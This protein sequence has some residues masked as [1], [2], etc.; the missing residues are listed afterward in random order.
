MQ[1]NPVDGVQ[2]QA[3]EL[4]RHFYWNSVGSSMDCQLVCTAFVL[5]PKALIRSRHSH[6][7][8]LRRSYDAERFHLMHKVCMDG[9]VELQPPTS[10]LWWSGTI[11]LIESTQHNFLIWLQLLRTNSAASISSLVSSL[12]IRCQRKFEDDF[13]TLEKA[14][15][16]EISS[17]TRVPEVSLQGWESLSAKSFC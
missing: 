1:S 5:T 16:Y 13:C 14:S 12:E 4:P 15:G 17:L 7:N 6:S 9:E 10:A 3:I 2:L 11:L 8:T